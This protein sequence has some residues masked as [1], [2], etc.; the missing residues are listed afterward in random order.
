LILLHP[1]SAATPLLKAR[2]VA[3]ALVLVV[4]C[5]VVAYAAAWTAET[6]VRR[7]DRAEAVFFVA[8]MAAT[9]AL[10]GAP[11]RRTLA[12]RPLR[13]DRTGAL[14]GAAVL[15]LLAAEAVIV[16]AGPSGRL[17]GLLAQARA[18]AGAVGAV[19]A[20]VLAPVGEELLFRG[21]LFTRLREALSAFAA[22]AVSAAA[23]AAFHA[24]H[25]IGYVVAMIPAGV[26]LGF[27]REQSGGVALPMLLHAVMNGAAAAAG[28]VLTAWPRLLG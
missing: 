28:L 7:S 21:L 17:E 3:A 22:V 26:F 18:E 12:L 13:L 23:F 19:N 4:L 24:E 14:Y 6:L 1:T 20:I 10:A 15:V 25:G 9:V 27:A 2:S 11:R 5:T 8:L 16:L